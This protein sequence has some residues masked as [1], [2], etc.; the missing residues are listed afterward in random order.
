M[1]LDD[2]KV[3]NRPKA[4]ESRALFL[5]AMTALV[6]CAIMVVGLM[7]PPTAAPGLDAITTSGIPA[8]A[9]QVDPTQK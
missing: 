5:I 6:A 3:G 9:S 2:E 1:F 7:S 8:A 4:R